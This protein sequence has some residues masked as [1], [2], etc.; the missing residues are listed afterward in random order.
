MSTVS[1]VSVCVWSVLCVETWTFGHGLR[2]FKFLKFQNQCVMKAGH[3]D[4]WTYSIFFQLFAK[5]YFVT[6]SDECEL[7]LLYLM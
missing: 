2:K 7:C 1:G 3:M 5:Y 6:C 4:I